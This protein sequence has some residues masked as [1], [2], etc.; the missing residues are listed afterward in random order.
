MRSTWWQARAGTIAFGIM[1]LGCS[2]EPNDPSDP[3]PD[4]AGSVVTIDGSGGEVTATLAGGASM[5]VTIPAGALQGATEISLQ[6][7]ER[8]PGE[9]AAFT[10]SPAGLRLAHPATI[11]IRLPDAELTPFS[12]IVFTQDD[13]TIPVPSDVSTSARTVTAVLNTLGISATAAQSPTA[14]GGASIRV[15]GPGNAAVRNVTLARRFQDA[16]SALAQLERVGTV[17][18]E[19]AMILSMLALIDV[20]EAT[21]R[22]DAR[23]PVLVS[24]WRTAACSQL[25]FALSVMETFQFAS[26]Y[27]GLLRVIRDV[28]DWGLAI[29]EMNLMMVRLGAPTCQN[30]ARTR[31]EA[32]VVALAEPITSDLNQFP[33]ITKEEWK[34]FFK[35]RL[36]PVLTIAAGFRAAAF[37]GSAVI[38]EGLFINQARRLRQNGF[39]N[40]AFS[41]PRSQDFQ[42]FLLDAEYGDPVFSVL[43]PYDTGTLEEDVEYC[44]MEI[45]WAVYDPTGHRR[46]LGRVGRGPAPGEVALLDTAALGPGDTLKIGGNLQALICPDTFSAN[47]EQLIIEGSR[48]LSNFQEVGRMTPTNDDRYLPD[49]ELGLT[50]NGILQAIGLPDTTSGVVHLRFRREGGLCQGAFHNLS[51][52]TLGQIE[53]NLDQFGIVTDTLATAHKGLAYQFQLTASAD[54]LWAVDDDDELPEGLSLSS[55]GVISGTPTEEGEFGV[56]IKAT[57]NGTTVF[58]QFT[59]KIDL[60]DLSGDW[61]GSFTVRLA[62]GGSASLSVTMHLIQVGSAVTGTWRADDVHNGIVFGFVTSWT[63]A[64]GTMSMDND[65]GGNFSGDVEILPGVNDMS[66]TFEGNDCHNSHEGGVVTLHR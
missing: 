19:D 35:D 58:K 10:I 7:A 18:A 36:G 11:V 28:V 41:T 51:H 21:A 27:A 57:G 6:P 46:A 26:D 48:T 47:N 3:D 20:D 16:D 8:Q 37:D 12:A 39:I 31:A 24:D 13:N 64:S 50:R 14:R 59:V 62:T 23:F 63:L 17:A 1:V 30:D 38:V 66:G 29:D 44:G 33:L 45:L 40:C 2:G 32:R 49:I 4:P 56:R 43:S 5:R 61:S 65:C 60:P 25:G 42:I 9:D 53:L 52:H 15:A 54:A 55:S 22:A 34:A